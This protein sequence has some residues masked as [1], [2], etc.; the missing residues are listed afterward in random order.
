MPMSSGRSALSQRSDGS[1]SLVVFRRR[2]VVALVAMFVAILFSSTM[3]AE[4]ATHA[5]VEF[6]RSSLTIVTR[7]GRHVF[8][9]E[10]AR[11]PDQ[12]ALGLMY[13]RSLP[14]DA[15]MLFDYRPPQR[16]AMWMHNTYIPLDMLFIA[17]DGRITRIVERTVPLSRSLILSKGKVRAVL[18][19]NGGTARR[20]GIRPGDR[21][22][23]EIFSVA[24]GRESAK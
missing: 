4:A 14:A 16:V 17:E 13:R 22:L 10:V 11:T 15:G 1:V 20:L 24:S 7:S 18:E 2:T 12:H 6:E 19:L 8:A 3:S 5:R 9:V 23:H 21:V